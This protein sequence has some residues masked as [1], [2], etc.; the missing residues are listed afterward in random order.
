MSMNCPFDPL[1]VARRARRDAAMATVARCRGRVADAEALRDAATL[2]LEV[3]V[4]DRRDCRARL[5]AQIGSEGSALEPARVADRIALLELRIGEATAELAA[6]ERA[7]EATRSELAEAV[8]AFLQAEKKLDALL[9]QRKEW[10]AAER[11][12]RDARDEAAV[13][14]MTVFRRANA[15]CA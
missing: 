3:I 10:T 12:A 1:I 9:A 13:E 2:R 7:L 5:Y 6:A 15:R 11:T 4:A 8:R 14:D